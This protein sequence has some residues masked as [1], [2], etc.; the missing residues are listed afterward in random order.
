[1]GGVRGAVRG[2]GAVPQPAPRGRAG[3]RTAGR[4]AAGDGGGR[5]GWRPGRGG[6]GRSVW[7]LLVIG[8]AV[9]GERAGVQ[10]FPLREGRMIDRYSFHLENAAGEDVD[11]VLEQFSLEYYGSAPALPP[12]TL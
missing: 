3:E 4:R 1:R 2:R 12:A 7:T 5:R 10:V 11:E 8:V 6:A 9:G